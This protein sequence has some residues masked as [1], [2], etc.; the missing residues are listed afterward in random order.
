[1]SRLRGFR[2]GFTLVE[3]LVVIAII[4]TLVGLLLPA[5]QTA[6]EAARRSSCINN[7][8]Q[9][10][11]AAMNYHDA[12]KAF[13]PGGRGYGMSS[14]DPSTPNY[15]NNPTASNMNGMLLLLPFMEQQT[16]YS[17]FNLDGAFGHYKQ[18]SQTLKSPDAT[19]SNN[20][21][22]T[23]T[24]IESL[25]CPSDSGVKFIAANSTAYYLPGNTNSGTISP[26][27]TSYEFVSTT[28]ESSYTSFWTYQSRHSA[29]TK[30]ERYIF[31][32]D[33]TTRITDVTDGTTQTFLMGERTLNSHEGGVLIPH[34]GNWAYRGYRHHGI[35]PY[36]SWAHTC[37]RTTRARWFAAPEEDFRCRRASIRAGCSSYS[38][39]AP[40]GS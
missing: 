20:A 8:K 7:L 38:P 18:S 34:T 23:A 11:I 28:R 3:L 10:G 32:E 17:Q 25:L 19:T 31:G 6:R 36:Q 2:S 24:L 5:V 16:L 27:K 22:L 39:T 14:A 12:R 9:L 40:Y 35:D 29:A 4:G 33:S 37:G 21:A 13:P 30:A 1:M 26:S 15:P